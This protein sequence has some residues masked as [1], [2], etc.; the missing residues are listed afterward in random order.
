MV[1]MVSQEYTA[2]TSTG[3]PECVLR[4]YYPIYYYLCV[5]LKGKGDKQSSCNTDE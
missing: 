5:L 1:I 3:F 4:Y 2:L